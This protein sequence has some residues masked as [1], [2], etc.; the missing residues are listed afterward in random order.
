MGG[1]PVLGT[2]EMLTLVHLPF[3]WTQQGHQGVLGGSLPCEVDL[4]EGSGSPKVHR[5][6]G[7]FVTCA[8]ISQ[9]CL[10]RSQ[11]KYFIKYGITPK[12]RQFFIYLPQNL[13]H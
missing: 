4:K 13:L 12:R 5:S 2:Q 7:P 3:T 11:V 1:P 8:F 9:C 6:W 10:L